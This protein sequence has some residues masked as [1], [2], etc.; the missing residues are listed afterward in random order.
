MFGLGIGKHKRLLQIAFAASL[1]PL[2]DELGNV[3]I[4][5]QTD[6]AINGAIL[7]ACE[8]YSQAHK[9]TKPSDIAIIADAVFEDLYRRESIQVQNRVD[10]WKSS[11]DNA[12]ITA[13]LDAK[14]K[15]NSEPDLGWLTEYAVNNFEPATGKML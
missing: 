2:K 7:G 4:P 3:P 9:I 15:T 8:A 6:P 5:M 10:E 12:F 11:N 1:R 13:Y 14:A